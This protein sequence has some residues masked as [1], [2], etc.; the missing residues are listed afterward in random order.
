MK[1]TLFTIKMCK[2][3]IFFI[4]YRKISMELVLKKSFK[5]RKQ[6]FAILNVVLT[7]CWL[8]ILIGYT[9][10]SFIFPIFLFYLIDSIIFGFQPY[11]IFYLKYFFIYSYYLYVMEQ[12]QYLPASRYL[13]LFF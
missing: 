6:I 12:R 10:H 11:I 4:I 13:F 2:L 5:N 7:K 3:F 8:Q 1:N 9:S